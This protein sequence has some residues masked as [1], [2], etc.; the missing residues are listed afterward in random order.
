MARGVCCCQRNLSQQRNTV[1]TFKHFPRQPPAAFAAEK[2]TIQLLASFS[3]SEHFT[4]QA[5][6]KVGHWTLRNGC[7]LM[8][9][10]HPLTEWR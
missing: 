1:D 2:I 10:S 3:L 5:G 6:D 9:K 7:V 8:W 4:R